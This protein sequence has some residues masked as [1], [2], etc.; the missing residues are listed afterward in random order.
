MYK[1]SKHCSRKKSN[2]HLQRVGTRSIVLSLT[3]WKHQQ[4]FSLR[5]FVSIV[6]KNGTTVTS[7][8][9]WSVCVVSL[10]LAVCQGWWDKWIMLFSWDFVHF[11]HRVSQKWRDGEPFH[12]QAFVFSRLCLKRAHLFMRGQFLRDCCPWWIC[13]WWDSES[14][15]SNS[16]LH[17]PSEKPH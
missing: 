15:R 7:F 14:R 17:P 1:R 12:G 2:K 9:H 4:E 3:P 11:Y 5:S 8:C 10:F 6:P 16:F 13:R